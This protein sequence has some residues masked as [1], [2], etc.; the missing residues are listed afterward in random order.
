MLAL[1][2][3]LLSA[4]KKDNHNQVAQD[5]HHSDGNEYIK[6]DPNINTIAISNLEA[7]DTTQILHI[8]DVVGGAA[9][10]T[11]INLSVGSQ[12][13]KFVLKKYQNVNV[14]DND[15]EV[16]T[17]VGYVNNYK[18]NRFYM[19]IKKQ[20]D[21]YIHF[22]LDNIFYII[23]KSRSG[24][25]SLINFNENEEKPDIRYLL[26]KSVITDKIKNKE[27][28]FVTPEFLNNKNEKYTKADSNVIPSLNQSKLSK[29]LN[30]VVN[31][32][33]TYPDSYNGSLYDKI[34]AMVHSF[35]SAFLTQEDGG[36]NLRINIYIYSNRQD[37][38]PWND[39]SEEYLKS[40]KS[41]ALAMYPEFKGKSDNTIF[42]NMHLD[43][44]W[45]SGETIGRAYVLDKFGLGRFVIV[46]YAD[47]FYRGDMQTLAHEVGHSLGAIHDNGIYSKYNTKIYDLMQAYTGIS[48]SK[49]RYREDHMH[50]PNIKR[51][52]FN[53]Q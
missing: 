40:W 19:F 38:T 18:K 27:P 37:R 7:L 11:Q 10:D 46:G 49:V 8:K 15:E 36:L 53:W 51:I 29:D 44:Q 33:G 52:M 24:K 17:A 42:V 3:S 28:I 34:Y 47:Q 5:M 48:G 23:K 26:N 6:D 25:Y 43:K 39:D 35:Y 13:L 30:V 31:V 12:K 50:Q 4:C 22:I 20:G 45:D 16:L 9:S 2:L 41:N 14:L 21:L 32:S 1:L